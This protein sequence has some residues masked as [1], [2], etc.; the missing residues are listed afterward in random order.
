MTPDQ[1][2]QTLWSIIPT[3]GPEPAPEMLFVTV[4]DHIDAR[5]LV[6]LAYARLDLLPP[7][8]RRQVEAVVEEKRVGKGRTLPCGHF[9]GVTKLG[10][11]R[12]LA[13]GMTVEDY[14]RDHQACC[15]GAHDPVADAIWSTTP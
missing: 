15:P 14:L 2:V 7:E 6:V 10:E 4:R 5:N 1:A 13:E 12:L 8:L 3:P 11:E 9:I